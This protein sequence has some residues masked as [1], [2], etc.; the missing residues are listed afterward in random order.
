[1]LKK[2][3]VPLDGSELAE[4]A[5]PYAL[6]LTKRL[7]M[8]TTLLHVC[9]VGQDTSLSMCRKYIDTTARGMEQKLDGSKKGGAVA[10][11]SAAFTGDTVI[12]I[13]PDSILIYTANHQSDMI[14]L[15][16]FGKTGNR[17]WLIGS[18]AH[19]ILSSAPVPVLIVQPDD[20]FRPRTDWPANVLVLLDGSELSETILPYVEAL[21]SGS[22]TTS[23]TL[24]QVCEPPDL[25]SD[26]PEAIMPLTWEEHVQKAKIASQERCRQYLKEI[27][28]KLE[29]RGLNVRTHAVIGNNVVEEIGKYA[30]EQKF[31]L[32]AMTT[33]GRSGMG[34]W[35]F[36]HIADRVIQTN[37]TPL[38]VVKPVPQGN[39]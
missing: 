25:L 12:G 5:L 1:M 32:V 29:T 20:D 18:V 2:L 17:K 21:E 28:D 15:S 4:D 27:G 16:R 38:L 37:Q 13:V 24:F 39:E 7:G 31:D 9:S 11:N 19:R 23:I 6:Q 22:K 33:H 10:K 26:Y 34:D 36:G 35:P 8:E 14:L 30:R 3:I